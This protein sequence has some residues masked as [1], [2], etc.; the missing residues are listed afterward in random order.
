[1]WNILDKSPIFEA[2]GKAITRFEESLKL[3][4]TAITRDSA[5]KRFE[6]CFDLAWKS[7]KVFAREQGVECYSPREC[8]KTAFQLKLITYNEN[9]IKMIEDRNLTT[10]LYK[11]ELADEVYQRLPIYLKLFKELKDKF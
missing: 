7:I 10:H 6:L 1:M 9:W 2:F 11:E 3:K 4:K 5:I 8:F